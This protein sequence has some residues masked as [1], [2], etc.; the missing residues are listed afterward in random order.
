MTHLEEKQGILKV[1]TV[2]RVRTTPKQREGLL[3]VAR[4]LSGW[5]FTE[6]VGVVPVIF[7]AWFCPFKI[8]AVKRLGRFL[9]THCFD[10]TD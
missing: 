9:P 6:I 1:N 4:G 10:L 3:E 5:L 2:G 7:S 8:C